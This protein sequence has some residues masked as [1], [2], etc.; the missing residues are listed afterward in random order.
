MQEKKQIPF[1]YHLNAEISEYVI[2]PIKDMLVLG[3]DAP[4]GSIAMQRAL[5]LLVNTPFENI[6]IENDP[7]I[8][9]ILVRQA[10]LRRI[11][12]T[13]LIDFVLENIKPIIGLEEVLHIELD[14]KVIIHYSDTING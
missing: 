12:R 9:D 7:I 5:T 2:P 4:I 10:L 6:A 3:K 11:P 1:K 8:S 13:G 14:A